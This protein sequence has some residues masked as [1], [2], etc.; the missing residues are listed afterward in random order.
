[1]AKKNTM[2]RRCS[3]LVTYKDGRVQVE[4]LNLE[5]NLPFT[6]DE[7]REWVLAKDGVKSVAFLG[8]KK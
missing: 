5:H 2:I 8:S 1:M 7:M 4:S 3:A 6:Q